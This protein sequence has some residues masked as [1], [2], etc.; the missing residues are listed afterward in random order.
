MMKRLPGS[1]K[2]V[3]LIIWWTSWKTVKLFRHRRLLPQAMRNVPAQNLQ[4]AGMSK[5]VKA[6]RNLMS[7]WFRPHKAERMWMVCVQASPMRCVN[8]VNCVIC[9]RGIWNS[10]P[11]MSGTASIISCRWNFR[12]RNS[13]VRLKNVCRAVKQQGLCRILP[14][15]PLH[16]GW[17]RI[18]TSPCNWQKW[19]FPKPVAVSKQRKK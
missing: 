16:Y 13:Q 5:G 11:K 8:S 12:S 15:M 1:L 2:M 10:L 6:S 9:C 3:W 4:F 14:K 7:T 17:T 19:P 18:L